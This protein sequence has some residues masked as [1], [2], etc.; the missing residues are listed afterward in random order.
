MG[1]CND[2][3][4]KQQ[5]TYGIGCE[6]HKKMILHPDEEK[7]CCDS[8]GFIDFFNEVIKNANTK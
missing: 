6:K 1:N 2:C 3:K 4:H 8:S 7:N 5:F